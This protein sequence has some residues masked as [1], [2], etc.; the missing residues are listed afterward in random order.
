MGRP[1]VAGLRARTGQAAVAIDNLLRHMLV[2]AARGAVWA[3]TGLVDG[4]GNEEVE[5]AVP[6]YGQLGVWALPPSSGAPEVIVAHLGGKSGNPVVVA[7]RDEATR[8]ALEEAL[9]GL[10]PGETAVFGA[11]G[12]VLLRADGTVE[13]RSWTGTAKRLVTEDD[14]AAHRSWVAAHIHADPVSGFTGA[15]TVAPPVPAYTSVLKGE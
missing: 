14:L 1:T 15:P 4:D 12:V 9:G 3:L 8:R 10:A 11:G 13:I 7:A 2:R 5:P 6:V